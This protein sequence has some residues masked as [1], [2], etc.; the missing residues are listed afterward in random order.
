MLN[1]K[2]R[3]WRKLTELTGYSNQGLSYINATTE[4]ITKE[5]D[6]IEKRKEEKLTNLIKKN[7]QQNHLLQD[8]I[9]AICLNKFDTKTY[10]DIL[11][12]KCNHTFHHH[13]IREFIFLQAVSL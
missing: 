12:L 8:K 2:T 9:C 4:D 10:N 11:T 13:C 5:I 7:T 1:S 6:R 3:A